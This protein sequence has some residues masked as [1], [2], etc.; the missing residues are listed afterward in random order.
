MRPA[1]TS[2]TGVA[3]ST[4]VPLDIYCPTFNVGLYAVVSGTVT[5]T[6]QA[7]GDDVFD[8]T[9]TPTWFSVSIAAMVGAT[10]NQSGNLT[11]PARAVRINQTAG[12]GTTT[13][14]V[15]QQSLA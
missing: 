15:V 7:T 14:T 2:V 10:A 9:V 5:Y 8:S 3:A 1:K 13:L 6:V 4:A 11:Q 12:T